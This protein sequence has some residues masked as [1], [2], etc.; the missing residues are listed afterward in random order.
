MRDQS[1]TTNQKLIDVA[2]AI[3]DAR[4]LLPGKPSGAGD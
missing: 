2:Q 1:R 3:L 4:A